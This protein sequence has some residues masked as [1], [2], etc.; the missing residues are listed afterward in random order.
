MTETRILIAEDEVVLRFLLSETLEDAGYSITE[1][2]DGHEAIL[3]LQDTC[4][5][6]IIVDYMMPEATGIEVCE[7]L[8]AGGG[9]N[10][11]KPVILLTAKVQEQDRI[12][13][14]VAGITKYISKP[15]SPIQLLDEVDALI[16]L[17]QGNGQ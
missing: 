4:F 2:A 12:R 6:L 1:A 15:F 11:A 10:A 3:R 16:Q 13:A 9:P 8:R 14:E 7:R 17:H 5:D